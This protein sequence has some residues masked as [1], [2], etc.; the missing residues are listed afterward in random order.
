MKHHQEQTS[1]EK[2]SSVKQARKKG[3]INFNHNCTKRCQ[4][5]WQNN[6]VFLSFHIPILKFIYQ[7]KISCLMKRQI[8]RC[9][10]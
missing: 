10:C 2:N 6:G 4:I 5:L 3:K 8:V 1:G 9:I 7:K